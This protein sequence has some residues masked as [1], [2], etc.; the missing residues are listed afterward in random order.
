MAC[1]AN[2]AITREATAILTRLKSV[3]WNYVGVVRTSAG[4]EHAVSE[5]TAMCD[6][7]ER[8]WD[9][10]EG[11]REAVALR[12]ASRSGLAVADAALRNR[13]SGGCHYLAPMA[14][15]EQHYDD[16]D[17]DEEDGQAMARA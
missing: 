6:E 17:D 11:G 1:R 13:I 8:L 9:T 3:M 5:L 10:G 15:T 14:E 16:D 7:A 2:D 12:D 4:L